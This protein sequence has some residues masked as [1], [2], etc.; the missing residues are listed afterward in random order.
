METPKK[1]SIQVIEKCSK[2]F[3]LLFIV[4]ILSHG[5]YHW[6]NAE[7][8][9]ITKRADNLAQTIAAINNLPGVSYTLAANINNI[10]IQNGYPQLVKSLVEPQPV[11]SD[12]LNG[13]KENE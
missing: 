5:L 7:Q 12:L 13:E 2:W 8:E 9:K 6:R 10:L 4:I 11:E 1:I 3:C